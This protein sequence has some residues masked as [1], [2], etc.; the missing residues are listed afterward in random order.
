[1]LKS[2]EKY[3]RVKIEEVDWR[4]ADFGK[5]LK[6]FDREACC[7]KVRKSRVGE[8]MFSSI[9][10]MHKGITL[11]AMRGENEVSRF[12]PEIRGVKQ[13]CGFSLYLCMVS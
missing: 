2:F 5:T 6:Y 4:F 8:G 12:V 13:G 9:Y 7:L 10:I 3:L 11:C 1:M